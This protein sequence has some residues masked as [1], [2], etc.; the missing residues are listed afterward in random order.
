MQ[1][2]AHAA[3]NGG[4]AMGTIV[5]KHAVESERTAASGTEAAY[6]E[7]V[8]RLR[9]FHDYANL[10]LLPPLVIMDYAYILTQWEPLLFPFFYYTMSYLI[11]DTIF[12][13]V[14]GYAHRSPRVVILHHLL[15]CL[16]SPLPYT[17]PNLRYACMVC[18]S[19]ELNTFALIARRRA[20]PNSIWQSIAS[21]VFVVSWFGIRCIVFPIMVYVFWVLWQNEQAASGNF[22]HPS[23]LAV[24]IMVALVV[25]QYM[26]TVGLVKKLTSKKYD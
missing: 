21:I 19:A 8:E 5:E 24:V 11:L 26:W 9:A 16:F 20:P 1:E 17:M 23:L 3:M 7:Q 14:Y 4:V 22:W 18:F 13:M 12:L 2:D 6:R 10:V 25:M 15:I